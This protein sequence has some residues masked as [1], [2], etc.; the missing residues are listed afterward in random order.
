MET[1][2]KMKR[3]PTDR[4]NICKQ[5]DRQGLNL[6]NM[7]TARV[8]QQQQQKTTQSKKWAEDLNKHSSKD[9]HM[10]N[11][12]MRRCSTPLIIREMK[13]KITHLSEWPSLKSLQISAGKGVE[14]RQL[15][16]F[17]V[18]G[19]VSWC[20]HDVKQYGASSES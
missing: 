3:Q 4:E 1:I 18:G 12:H 17:N 19:N 16:S 20:S 9:I 10:A 2:N 7:K 5:Y 6:Q 8:A 14:I 15:S 13:I 11:R